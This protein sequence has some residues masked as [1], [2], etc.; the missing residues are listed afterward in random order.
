MK[1]VIA[2]DK[3][4][5]TLSA[6]EACHIAA[7]YFSARGMQVVEKPMADGGEGT[8]ESLLAANAGTWIPVDVTGPL[9]A[10]RVRAGF[11]WFP[12]THTALIEMATAS[13]L[14]LLK[15]EQRNPLA[16]TTRGTG[17]LIDAAMR[18]GASS[19]L[20]AIGG[21]ATNDGG[22]GAAIALGW[23]FFD[24]QDNELAPVGASLIKIV[25]LAPPPPRLLPPVEVL[26]DVTNPLFG[27][28]GAAAV[29]G[30]QK[31]ATPHMVA[32]LDA[33]LRNLAGVI[34]RSL[35][36][37]V[38]SLPGGGAAGGLGAGAVA[39]MS[40]RLISGITAVMQACRLED[41][42]RTA[43]YVI[44][45]EGALDRQSLMGKVLSGV[46]KLA[47]RHGVRVAVIAGRIDLTEHELRV[48]G[49]SHALAL[50]DGATSAETAMS[51]ARAMF[52]VRAKTLAEILSPNTPALQ[53]SITPGG[54][55]P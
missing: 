11:A 12:A 48:A 30:P 45:G 20:L 29:F 38:D 5:G 17:E 46:L 42:I 52:A 35:G 32:E 2:F 8:A 41:A 1:V 26:C 6:T 4:K 22:I 13:G 55:Q 10:M 44:T 34:A 43:D 18:H 7:A 21:S 24:A 51:N 33:G 40:A 39:F 19:I 15:P 31:G 9:P 28:Q 47:Q 50:I 16:T 36:Q 14:A 3:F 25:R 37:N 27:P 23:R 54:F 49:I 53:H